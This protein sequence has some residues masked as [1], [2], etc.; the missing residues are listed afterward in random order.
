MIPK[1]VR[2]IRVRVKPCSDRGN[3]MS[4]YDCQSGRMSYFPNNGEAINMSNVAF[5]LNEAGLVAVGSFS[6]KEDTFVIVEEK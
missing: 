3:K 1:E 4:F 6:Y 2:A 5:H